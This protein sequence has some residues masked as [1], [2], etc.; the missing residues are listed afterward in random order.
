MK[1]NMIQMEIASGRTTMSEQLFRHTNPWVGEVDHEW[2]GPD[3]LLDH[4]PCFVPVDGPAYQIE[5]LAK[6]CPPCDQYLRDSHLG[7]CWR[8]V[9]IGDTK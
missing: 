8:L 1:G 2:N 4:G 3:S 7:E 5:R 6:E 9:E